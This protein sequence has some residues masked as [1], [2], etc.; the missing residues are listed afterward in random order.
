MHLLPGAWGGAV[1]DV[2]LD[3]PL[4]DDHPFWICPNTIITQHS[5]GG[6]MDE[7]DRKIDVFAANLTRYRNGEPLVGT[8]DFSRGY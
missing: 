6:T 7:I 8:V 5:G 3:E 4:P 2:T 1:I